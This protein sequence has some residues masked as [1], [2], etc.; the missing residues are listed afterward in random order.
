MGIAGPDIQAGGGIDIRIQRKDIHLAGLGRAACK[1]QLRAIDRLALKAAVDGGLIVHRVDRAMDVDRIPVGRKRE[2]RQEDG[3]EHRAAGDRHRLFRLQPGVAALIGETLILGRTQRIAAQLRRQGAGREQLRNLRRA[4]VQRPAAAQADI[5][6]HLAG[7]AE[8]P[9]FDLAAGG[10]AG[11]APRGVEIQRS[12]RSCFSR[13]AHSLPGSLPRHDTGR[14]RARNCP[15]P[16]GRRR[17]AHWP[18]SPRPAHGGIPRRTPPP[19]HRPE[20]ARAARP[21]WSRTPHPGSG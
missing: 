21:A 15:P 9:G 4:D 11:D 20:A 14:D 1:H 2:A 16:I 7:Q 17:Q 3:R 10:I 13:S 6:V 19:R 12:G 5:V 18:G 8:L